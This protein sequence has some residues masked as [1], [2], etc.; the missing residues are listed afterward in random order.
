MSTLFFLPLISFMI[1][2]C[3]SDMEL[4]LKHDLPLE[5]KAEAKGYLSAFCKSLKEY[6]SQRQYDNV[7]VKA[8]HMVDELNN[9]PEFK[10]CLGPYKS[11]DNENEENDF[12]AAVGTEEN[13]ICAVGTEPSVVLDKWFY[14]LIID[15]SFE[16]NLVNY[17][18]Y[19]LSYTQ[20]YDYIKLKRH[21]LQI[22]WNN[23]INNSENGYQKKV[24]VLFDDKGEMKCL[25]MYFP[26][27]VMN[28]YKALYDH[29][30]NNRNANAVPMIPMNGEL[31]NELITQINEL[32]NEMYINNAVLMV[33]GAVITLICLVI[34]YG[35]RRMN[36]GTT[37]R[38]N[39]ELIEKE[40]EV[41][42]CNA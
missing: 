34:I 17:N 7:K 10:W 39:V 1:N 35:Y 9:L 12:C 3:F 20:K 37:K 42:L 36:I 15:Q 33:Y 21:K 8:K 11:M 27:N 6:Q 31:N 19:S 16:C 29:E 26:Q 24:K 40:E 28:E 4:N 22:A 5:S 38:E 23:E 41:L 14:D 2:T 25:K 30:K 18:D 32:K 13:D